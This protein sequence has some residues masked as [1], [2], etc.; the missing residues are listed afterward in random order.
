MEL[1][2]NGTI[3]F[4]KPIPEKGMKDLMDMEIDGFTYVNLTAPADKV[5]LIWGGLVTEREE[6][7]QSAMLLIDEVEGDISDDLNNVVFILEHYEIS[8]LVGEC[9]RY[10]GDYE[11]YDV[12]TGEKF[13]SMDDVDYGAW[14]VS[15]KY[16]N[17]V[18]TV[19]HLIS[20]FEK[21]G[22]NLT[23]EQYEKIIAAHREIEKLGM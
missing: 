14:L 23:H 11:G 8:P 3:R 6:D 19:K 1:K 20:Y 2:N 16:A 18:I 17:L 22:G 13:E 7:A 9:N 21:H 10:Y 15:K 12:F 4:N 5:G